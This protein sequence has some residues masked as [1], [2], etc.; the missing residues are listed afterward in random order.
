MSFEAWTRVSLGDIVENISTRVDDP[1][2]SGLERFV[3]L[4]HLDSGNVAVSRW[5]S[6]S[7][8]ASGKKFESGDVL[9]CRRRP[10]L[11]KCSGVDFD[12]VCSGDA[13]VLREKPGAVVPG[14]LKYILNTNQFWEFAIANADGS[15][16]T[17]VKYR[18]L[19]SYVFDLPPESRQRDILVI[20]NTVS[21]LHED[22]KRIHENSKQ[23]YNKFL[24]KLFDLDLRKKQWKENSAMHG[25]ADIVP[26][27]DRKD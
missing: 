14:L 19:Q 13:Y 11:R 25:K 17:R 5:G 16:S 8:F 21:K 24:S 15:M 27:A 20:L 2:K 22:N 10:Y 23:A 3:G 12:G 9:L 26:L 18:H 7:E 4:E 1:S 6:T